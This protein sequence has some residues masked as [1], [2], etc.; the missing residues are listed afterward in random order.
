MDILKETIKENGMVHFS[1]GDNHFLAYNETDDET[2]RTGFVVAE[3][4]GDFCGRCCGV[5]QRNFDHYFPS[6]S[7]NTMT[8]PFAFGENETCTIENKIGKEDTVDLDKAKTRLLLVVGDKGYDI[9]DKNSEHLAEFIMQGTSM[10]RQSEEAVGCEGPWNI[11]VQS[12]EGYP[13]IVATFM[14]LVSAGM[15]SQV[16]FAYE[17]VL[18]DLIIAEREGD[19]T[20]FSDCYDGFAKNIIQASHTLLLK[21]GEK[22]SASKQYPD[23]DKIL[24]DSAMY[25]DNE[26]LCNNASSL[27]L[28]ALWKTSVYF[29]VS[30]FV[31]QSI[32]LLLYI[33]VIPW[34]QPFERQDSR[35]CKILRREIFAAYVPIL[36]SCVCGFISQYYFPT[37]KLTYFLIL[38]GAGITSRFLVLLIYAYCSYYQC[39]ACGCNCGYVSARRCSRSLLVVAILLCLTY[40]CLLIVFL[41]HLYSPD[42]ANPL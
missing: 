37:E 22:E 2:G 3:F 23:V 1:I 12:L 5:G 21:L 10:P 25:P 24:N 8:F 6:G 15:A 35:Y 30:W 7:E 41:V 26:D 13:I 4:R 18:L 11:F 36:I 38:V 9:S 16:R 31:L 28:E 32:A 19:N 40:L 29:L 20:T 34:K 33:R 42:L 14:C 39:C 17:D 27:G